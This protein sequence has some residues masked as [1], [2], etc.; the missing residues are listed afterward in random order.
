MLIS[1]YE[2]GGY[3]D[4]KDDDLFKKK[5]TSIIIDQI[6]CGNLN[7]LMK[8][9]SIFTILRKLLLRKKIKTILPYLN[10]LKFINQLL[11]ATLLS[12][13]FFINY[14]ISLFITKKYKLN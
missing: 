1:I 8:S 2:E 12:P 10:N 13:I 9:Y 4:T 11:I 5:Y 7:L 6:L 3:S 14:L